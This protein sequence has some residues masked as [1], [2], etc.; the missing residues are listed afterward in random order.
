M[1]LC[2]CVKLQMDNQAVL[3]TAESGC[4]SRIHI[5]QLEFSVLHKLCTSLHL[6]NPR[7]TDEAE[8]GCDWKEGSKNKGHTVGVAALLQIFAV[9]QSIQPLL[10]SGALHLQSRTSTSQASQVTHELKGCRRACGIILQLRIRGRLGSAVSDGSC[11]ILAQ[12]RQG[13]D[14]LER[15]AGAEAIAIAVAGTLDMDESVGSLEQTFD[16]IWNVHE[17]LCEGG[18]LGS[19]CES[20]VALIDIGSASQ[21]REGLAIVEHTWT[22]GSNSCRCCCN[23]GKCLCQHTRRKA[24]LDILAFSQ[25]ATPFN[26]LQDNVDHCIHGLDRGRHIHG[27]Q[28]LV[29]LVLAIWF[30][31]ALDGGPNVR[32]GV[33]QVV[34]STC[35]VQGTS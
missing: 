25:L 11:E 27:T 10:A 5:Y 16:N 3:S 9:L 31:A 2:P 26:S 34:D 12:G 4:D 18:L 32:G 8:H 21:E 22:L 7:A 29:A 33:E 1:D 6:R 20:S 14:D 17:A 30:L 15:V 35:T 23:S 24:A 13:S 28:K 19:G